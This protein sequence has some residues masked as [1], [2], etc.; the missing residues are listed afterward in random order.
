[1]SLF[2]E[3]AVPGTA[4]H[5]G[6]VLADRPEVSVE[7]DRVGLVGGSRQYVWVVGA[8]RSSILDD[9]RAA[10]SVPSFTV[11]DEIADRTLVRFDSLH[12]EETILDV[13]DETAATLADLEGS[14]GEWLV[15][16]QTPGPAEFGRLIDRCR[17]RDL[18]IE[19]RQ[20]YTTTDDPLDAQQDLTPAQRETI[21]AAY[22][23]GYF[24]V[25]R[26]V[27]LT[28]LAD[29]LRVSEQALSERLRRGLGTFLSNHLPPDQSEES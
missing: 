7:F 19:V 12:R 11:L 27:T 29:G 28:E 14:D 6:P 22:E 24:D 21:L 10:E 4:L 3:V 8:S 18:T 20:V 5:P 16:L 17:A 2:A 26:T 9:L 13:L 25:P 1:M 15:R 23:A